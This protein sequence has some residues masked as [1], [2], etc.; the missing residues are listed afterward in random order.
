[1][2]RIHDST[3]PPSKS[4]ASEVVTSNDCP[5]FEEAEHAS[6]LFLVFPLRATFLPLRQV[7]CRRAAKSIKSIETHL[8]MV[9]GYQLNCIE[10]VF[11]VNF[12]CYAARAVLQSDLKPLFRV[13]PSTLLL[14]SCHLCKN[15]LRGLELDTRLSTVGM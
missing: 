10:K 9:L 15:L 8:K 5:G 3:V 11:N 2:T 6:S 7:L 1:M 12:G 4:V 14:W 13:K